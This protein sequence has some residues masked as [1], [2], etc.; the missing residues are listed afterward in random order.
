MGEAQAGLGFTGEWHDPGLGMVYLRARWYQPAVGRFTQRDPGEGNPAHPILFHPY[1]YA[2]NN[3][4]NRVDPAGLFPIPPFLPSPPLIEWLLL[5]PCACSIWALGLPAN[6]GYYEDI[7]LIF[8]LGIGVPGFGVFQ[9]E[10]FPIVQQW[11]GKAMAHSYNMVVAGAQIVF[12]FLH[13]QSA[14]F[15]YSGVG[16]D[17]LQV[18]G[19]EGR[20][21]QGFLWGFRTGVE[22]YAGFAMSWGIGV[23]VSESALEGGISFAYSTPLSEQG[24]PSRTGVYGFG[25]S[26]AV[27]I[28]LGASLPIE[29]AGGNFEIA[30]YEMIPGTWYPYEDFQE[31]YRVILNP[32]T[33]AILPL[34]SEHIRRKGFSER[35]SELVQRGIVEIGLRERSAGSGWRSWAAMLLALYE[36]CTETAHPGTPSGGS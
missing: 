26:M 30:K 1:L 13:R 24:E 25:W 9:P 17:P 27:E 35:L 6:L 34:A 22:N 3:P 20:Y 10:D 14:A 33:A 23:S 31:M 29:E 36:T 2:S 32:P 18:V 4:I 21:G 19:L 5:N 8:T 12:D 7:G 15:Y 28:G 11:Y 16:W